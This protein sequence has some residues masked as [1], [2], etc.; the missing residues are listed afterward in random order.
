MPRVYTKTK[1]TRGKT[2]SCA[3]CPEPIKAGQEYHEWKFRYAGT[4]RQHASHGRPS[5]GQLTQSKLGQ[6]YDAQDDAETAIHDAG[7]AEDIA[8][9]VRGVGETAKEVADEYREAVQAMNMEGA[10]TENEERADTLDEYSE[11][12]E[13]EAD[14]ISS[15]QWEADPPDEGEDEEPV[16]S[17]GNTEE[18][19]LEELRSR[20]IEA[21]MDC[22]L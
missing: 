7:S 12:L 20:A 6:L 8:E 1:S 13:G 2:Y 10:G 9:A 11:K 21:I 18:E 15:E 4:R 19:W 3:K 16:D 14:D 17:D 5:R 22:D